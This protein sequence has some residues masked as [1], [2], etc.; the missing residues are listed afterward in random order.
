MACL[1]LI[2]LALFAACSRHS[3]RF[4][5]EGTFQNLNQGEFYVYSLGTPLPGGLDTIKVSSGRFSRSWTLD[6][7][8][9]LMLVFTNFS[10][11]PVFAQPGATVTIS[12]DASHLREMAVSGTADNKLMT[13]F[14]HETALMSPPDITAR[15]AQFIADNP[16]SP[17][18]RYLLR[19][20]FILNDAADRNE[21]LR[22]AQLIAEAVPSA[23]HDLSV[24]PI[25]FAVGDTLPPFTLTDINGRTITQDDIQGRTTVVTTFAAWSHESINMVRTLQPLVKDYSDNLSA[26]SISLDATPTNCRNALRRDTLSW[27]VVCDRLMFESPALAAF[28]LC[29]VPDN[30]IIAPDGTIAA[31]SVPTNELPAT[32]QNLLTR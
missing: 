6:G 10:E 20:W 8:T 15:A 21:T 18:S 23:A 12:A 25:G 31:L 27:P 1:L 7:A 19:R 24:R 3:N 29:R 32:L 16:A 2:A 22:L 5:L 11:Q 28:A 9:T 30:I 14:R 4:T 26:I 17:V 13:R